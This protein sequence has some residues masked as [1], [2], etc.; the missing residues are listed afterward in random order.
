MLA[1]TRVQ[2]GRWQRS[3]RQR[4][5]TLN[6]CLLPELRFYNQ[7]RS[8]L[9]PCLKTRCRVCSACLWHPCVLETRL[10]AGT[11]PQWRVGPGSRENLC[12]L[13]ILPQPVVVPPEMSL[14]RP[15]NGACCLWQA[16]LGL[17]AEARIWV[18]SNSG[19]TGSL[20]RKTLRTVLPH[21]R[22]RLKASQCECVN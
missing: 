12:P 13:P 16:D 1:K 9:A 15:N 21:G 5:E 8:R 17:E 19:H 11:R 20:C 14:H 18:E 3:C 6:C 4:P 22:P 7:K 2:T 10:E